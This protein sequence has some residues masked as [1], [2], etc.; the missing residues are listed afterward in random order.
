MTKPW[1][2]ALLVL[3]L[4]ASLF[5]ATTSL[6]DFSIIE[7]C[8]DL[9]SPGMGNVTGTGIDSC[10]PSNAFDDNFGASDATTGRWLTKGSTAELVYTFEE[11]TSV[12]HY[13]ISSC[14]KHDYNGQTRSPKNFTLSG[15]NADT[16]EWAVL[17]ERTLETEWEYAER[18]L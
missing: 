2:S 6:S 1:F 4:T 15:R 8:T 3:G 10:P 9:T 16:E 14:A 17:D 18:R 13:T 11:A 7:S 12:T 5:A